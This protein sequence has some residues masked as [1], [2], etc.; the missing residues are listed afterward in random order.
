MKI[1]S[2]NPINNAKNIS[3]NKRVQNFA[4]NE[5]KTNTIKSPANPEYWQ[6]VSFKALTFEE[7]KQK[8]IKNKRKEISSRTRQ[9]FSNEVYEAFIDKR[10]GEIDPLAEKMFN[11]LAAGKDSL[12][13]PK[14][15]NPINNTAEKVLTSFSMIDE[16]IVDFINSI[17]DN[18]GISNKQNYKAM[19]SLLKFYKSEGHSYIEPKEVAWKLNSIKGA[20]GIATDKKLKKGK[21]FLSDLHNDVG[22]NAISG[23]MNSIFQFPEEKID[24]I[25]DFIVDFGKNREDKKKHNLESFEALATYCFDKDGNKIEENINYAEKLMDN[26]IV[27]PNPKIFEIAENHPNNKAFLLEL[28]KHIG[29]DALT[30][31]PYIYYNY[32][33]EDGSLPQHIE[34]KAIQFAKTTK[35]VL[36]FNNVYSSCIEKDKTFNEEKFK[37]ALSLIKITDAL[38]VNLQRNFW[39]NFLSDD[40]D[41]DKLPFKDKVLVRNVLNYYFKYT[42]AQEKNPHITQKFLE[43]K[44]SINP[45]VNTVPI[46]EKAKT[47]FIN[48]VMSANE[49]GTTKFEQTIINAKPLFET[50]DNGVPLKYSR[51]DFLKDFEK[52]CKDFNKDEN[53]EAEKLGIKLVRGYKGEIEGYDGFININNIE[54][55]NVDLYNI[56]NNFLYENE[57]TTQ[58]EELNKQLNYIIKAFPEFI[59]IIGKKQHDTHNYTLDIHTLLNLS[60]CLNNPNYYKNLNAKDKAFLKLSVIFHDITKQ[61]NRIDSNHPHKSALFA[62]SCIPRIIKDS[63]DQNRIYDIIDNHH[64]SKEFNTSFNQQEKAAE[65]A[66]RFR[67]PNDFEIAKIMAKADLKAVS[68]YFYDEYKDCLKLDNLKPIQDYLDFIYS[69]GNTIFTN[70]IVDKAKLKDHIQTK[71]DKEYAVID[72]RKISNETEMDE[73]GFEKGVK[74]EDLNFLVHAIWDTKLY[75]TLNTLNDLSLSSSDGVLSQTLISPEHN[76]LYSNR[77]YGVILTEPNVSIL[78]MNDDNLNSGN[79]K[80]LKSFAQ[81]DFINLAPSLRNYYRDEVFRELKIDPKSVSKEEYAE[82]YKKELADAKSLKEIEKRETFKVGEH[83]ISGKAL[84]KALKKVQQNLI[85]P[86][87]RFHNEIVGATPNIEAVFAK[88]TDFE[89]LP[90]DLLNFAYEN[91]YPIYLF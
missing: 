44:N 12:I 45:T 69:S 11:I 24:E 21:F 86:D 42:P 23:V 84:A 18:D 34:E 17:K 3:T 90:Q 58:N 19:I 43:L 72:F 33:Q 63:D 61:E 62:K 35:D 77:K 38:N 65:L 39:A 20:S 8:N 70:R 76:K 89:H 71:N 85:D 10:T 73:Y 22:Y 41:T 91:D 64:W 80:S 31:L 56:V 87:R 29:K 88:G 50:F 1:N 74:K 36:F 16:D 55:E 59:N 30:Q 57:V 49:T 82:F 48:N 9:S 68:E 14:K 40:F 60:N 28:S 66:L 53:K 4:V 32:E 37:E 78:M 25:F 46:E 81:E 6:S 2:I 67:R 13:E 79:K 27:I 54:F 26:N 5:H 15:F 52:Y 51:N 47:D 75:E 7:I 83:N